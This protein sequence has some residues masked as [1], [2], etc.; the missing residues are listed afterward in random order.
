MTQ[1]L[2][3]PPVLRAT[4]TLPSSKSES[5]RALL[6]CALSGATSSVEHLS[7]CDDTYVMWRALTERPDVIDV[8]AAGTA[9]RFLTAYFAV[10]NSEEHLITGTERMLERPVSVLVDSLR[11]LGADI[12]Y[13]GREGYPPVRVKGCRLRGGRISLPADVSSQY[14]SAL[15]MTG[16][17][18]E[19]GLQLNLVG[20]IMSRPYIDMTLSLMRHFGVCAEWSGE[21]VLRV[22][23]Q[24]Y[25]DGV[26]FPVESDW[27]A[28]S[29]WYEMV[30]LSSDR[31]ASVRLPWLYEKSLQGDSKVR[32][33]FE[34]LGVR[35][36]FNGA[37]GGV[38]LTKSSARELQAGLG[39]LALDL[40][41]QPDLAQTLVVTCAMLRR[42]FRFSGLRSLRIKETDRIEALC[43]GLAHFGIAL[44]AEGDDILYIKE[45]SSSSP[46][47]DGQP[48]PTFNDHRMAMSFAPAALLCDGVRIAEPHVVSKSY[49][50]FWHDLE[51]AGVTYN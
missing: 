38:T 11:A 3:F 35:T 43:I 21:N 12:A 23:R 25:A 4:I 9:M 51:Q 1:T 41:N 20:E 5:N 34:S 15:L 28:A 46:R 18:M 22:P 14:V 2:H 27:S 30:A 45:Y 10:C 44:Q 49:P 42:K 6:L 29:Y 17:L 39:E 26:I 8:H 32:L 33:F 40:S 19:D 37:D 48:I 13:E 7:S 47:Y 36:V 16:P 24:N 31:Q 50:R